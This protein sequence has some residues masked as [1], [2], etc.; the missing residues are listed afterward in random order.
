VSF[1][2]LVNYLKIKRSSNKKY[3]YFLLLIIVTMEFFKKI[4]KKKEE[5]AE[6]DE[7][8]SLEM[9]KLA[10]LSAAKRSQ[11][12]E[13]KKIQ[14]EIENTKELIKLEEEKLRLEEIREKLAEIRGDYLEED[15]E[16][17]DK[18][19][20]PETLLMGILTSAQSKGLNQMP[21]QTMPAPTPV[22]QP[23]FTDEQMKEGLGKLFNKQQL[24]ILKN[25][26][27]ADILQAHRLSKGL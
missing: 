8:Y 21:A 22:Q 9:S 10:E 16:E 18:N 2:F 17:E 6:I 1:T 12:A 19:F 15:E 13:R 3:I 24:E 23:K 7:E 5:K 14:K 27:E 4:F 11:Y 26:D 20:N 25:M